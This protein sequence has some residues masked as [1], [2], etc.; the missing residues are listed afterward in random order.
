MP[1]TLSVFADRDDWAYNDYVKVYRDLQVNAQRAR[2]LEA[3]LETL[4]EHCSAIEA[5]LIEIKRR[6]VEQL[7]ERLHAAHAAPRPG[8][9][10]WLK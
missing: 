10:R 3:E 8:W 5:E 4:R 1:T 7:K 9:R 2:T 6:E